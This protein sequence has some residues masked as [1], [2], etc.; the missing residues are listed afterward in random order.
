LIVLLVFV[1]GPDIP[2]S[3]VLLAARY[4]TKNWYGTVLESPVETGGP[5]NEKEV[6]AY[7]FFE[8]SFT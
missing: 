2:I 6:F 8:A 3:K 7:Y 5:R 4:T 1:F